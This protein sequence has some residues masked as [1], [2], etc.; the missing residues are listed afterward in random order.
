[1]RTCLYIGVYEGRDTYIKPGIFTDGDG[2]FK[3][4]GKGGNR[5]TIHSLLVCKNGLENWIESLEQEGKDH[6]LPYRMKF[7]GINETEYLRFKTA[8]I[9]YPLLTLEK[10]ID[11]YHQR[12]AGYKGLFWVKK[13]FFPITSDEDSISDLLSQITKNPHKYIDVNTK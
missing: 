10:V 6:F 2:R 12:T 11:W 1:M 8:P 5:M 4:Y 7:N 9:G 3:S 13:E